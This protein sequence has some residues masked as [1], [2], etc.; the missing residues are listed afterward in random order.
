PPPGG[1][2]RDTDPGPRG[3][4][5]SSRQLENFVVTPRAHTKARASEVRWA[6]G[7][8][9]SATAPYISEEHQERAVAPAED[10]VGGLVA[11]QH[12]Q[13]EGR[14]ERVLPRP[15]ELVL[16]RPLLHRVPRA[17]VD[18]GHGEIVACFEE[19]RPARPLRGQAPSRLEARQGPG[20]VFFL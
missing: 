16:V 12:A 14:V 3:E 13:V 15:V 5:S 8:S 10:A 2:T 18:V 7:K 4:A 11:E 6:P 17:Q 20:P 1:S 9:S 19:V